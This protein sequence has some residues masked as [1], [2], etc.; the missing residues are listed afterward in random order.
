MLTGRRA[1]QGHSSVET[2]TADPARRPAANIQ[3][4]RAELRRAHH[5]ALPRE[6]RLRAIPVGWRHRLRPRSGPAR[7]CARAD[8]AGL[9]AAP[10][11]AAD[12]GDR[13]RGRRRAAGRGL[14][15]VALHRAVRG[16]QLRAA[17]LRSRG[18][19]PTRVSCP[20]ASRSSTAPRSKDSSPNSSSSILTPK[21]LSRSASPTRTSSPCR[22]RAS[23]Q[24]SPRHVTSSS[25]CSAARCRG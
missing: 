4:Q 9:A 15:P 6:E 19:S 7:Q 10:G 17:D 22:A 16:G 8:T 21:R 11:V 13:R 1:F 5:P 24:S 12:G 14:R 25:A 18:R 3:R 20:T 2:L 23:W